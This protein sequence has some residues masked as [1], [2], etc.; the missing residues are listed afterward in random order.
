M[1][2]ASE[3]DT[4]TDVDSLLETIS[5]ERREKEDL[6]DQLNGLRAELEAKSSEYHLL[7]VDY[8]KRVSDIEAVLADLTDGFDQGNTL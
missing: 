8:F 5:Q 6:L 3:R 1:K 7:Q 2:L 4:H